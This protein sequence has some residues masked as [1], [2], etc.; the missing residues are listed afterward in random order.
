MQST[1]SGAPYLYAPP[2]SRIPVYKNPAIRPTPARPSMK[3]AGQQQHPRRAPDLLGL[4]LRIKAQDAGSALFGLEQAEQQADGRRLARAVVAPALGPAI[5]SAGLPEQTQQAPG[6][7][8][9][10]GS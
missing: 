1:S 3:N 5:G 6:D 2:S 9:R 8:Q 10:G 4:R 7:G